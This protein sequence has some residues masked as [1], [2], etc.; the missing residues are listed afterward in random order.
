MHILS[1]TLNGNGKPERIIFPS[2][3]QTRVRAVPSCSVLMLLCMFIMFNPEFQNKTYPP[4]ICRNLLTGGK[5]NTTLPFSYGAQQ[6]TFFIATLVFLCPLDPISHMLKIL[7][8]A[9]C[10]GTLYSFY[11]VKHP[12]LLCLCSCVMGDLLWIVGKSK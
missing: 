7:K 12:H 4:S 11:P 8:I 10:R 1:F 3:E 2:C 6:R 5:W 9:H